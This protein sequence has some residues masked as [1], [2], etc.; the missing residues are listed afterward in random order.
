MDQE[1]GPRGTG[2]R[3]RTGDRTVRT[4]G[5][6][7]RLVGNGDYVFVAIDPPSRICETD[8][9]PAERTDSAV[10]FLGAAVACE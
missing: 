3:G 10:A 7:A 4:R 2:E 9:H 6:V 8:G 5:V 1:G